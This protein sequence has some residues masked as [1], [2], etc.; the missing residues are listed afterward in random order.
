MKF[1]VLFVIMPFVIEHF[2]TVYVIEIKD[3]KKVLTGN[4]KVRSLT[5]PSNFI[6]FCEINHCICHI[7]MCI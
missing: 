1:F 3:F 7:N 4:K 5:N 6:N 2:V